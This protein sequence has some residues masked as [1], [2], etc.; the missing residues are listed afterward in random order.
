MEASEDRKKKSDEENKKMSDEEKKTRE[1]MIKMTSTQNFTEKGKSI[2]PKRGGQ[3]RISRNPDV[4]KAKQ[5][6]RRELLRFLGQK[7]CWPCIVVHKL[8]DKI[9]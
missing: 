2:V 6:R 3:V 4:M 9:T 5:I 8:L 7:C 1:I